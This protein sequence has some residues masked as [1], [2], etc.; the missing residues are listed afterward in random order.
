MMS[1][2]ISSIYRKKILN[3]MVFYLLVGTTE[4]AV[5]CSKVSR[6][7]S[8]T[9]LLVTNFLNNNVLCM[10]VCAAVSCVY[11]NQ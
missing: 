1:S 11:M 9:S 2:S 5:G 7:D 6:E 4:V 8:S 3:K 10:S